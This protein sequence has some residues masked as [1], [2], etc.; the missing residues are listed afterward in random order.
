MLPLRETAR[1]FSAGGNRIVIFVFMVFALLHAV[2]ASAKPAQ[3]QQGLADSATLQ[4][5]V[6]DSHG[7]PLASATVYLQAETKTQTLTA[8]TDSRG[9]FYFS[10]LGHG[11]YTV[12][13]EMA[14]YGE[15]TFGPCVLGA[16]ETKRVDLTLKAEQPQFFDEPE[17]TVAGVT[18]AMNPGGHGSDTILRTTEALAKETAS[19]SKTPLN[20]E[21][22][23]SQ[24]ASAS[25]GTAAEKSLPTVAEQAPTDFDANYR[26]G[27][28]LVDDGKAR[29]AL[30]YL[31]RASQLNPGNYENCYELAFAYAAAGQYER[32]LAQARI[33]LARPD[34]S[35]QEEGEL[36]HLLGDVEEKI[37]DPLEAVR[38]YQRAAELNP[39]ESNLF[40]WG[41][42]LLMHRAYEPAIGVFTKGNR[43]FPQSARMLAGLS[44]AA[45]ARGAYDQA[46]ERLCEAS[47]LSPDDPNPYL[48]LGKMQS[49][50]TAQSECQVER[51]RRFAGLQPENALANYYYA[52]SLWNRHESS[53]SAENVG[54]VESL[55]EKSVHLDPKFGAAYLQLG[56][57]YA[58][59]GDSASAISAYQK[60]TEAN[61]ELEEAHYR[62]AQA[63]SRAGDKSKAEAELQLYQQLSKKSADEAQHERREIQQFVFTLRGSSSALQP[64]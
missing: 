12:R 47:D 14:G 20:K 25:P 26:L 33:L 32:G 44:V 17:F 15:T 61:P 56:I 59:R 1:Y 2:P 4:G 39:S 50:R 10:A 63:Y 48:F 45:Y 36:H 37:G 34:K 64:Q 42:D 53:G 18:E 62:L 41:T 23:N 55:L 5:S 43:L 9:T 8:R 57:L 3:A 22:D 58:E 60:A 11:T 46:A 51:L 49:V 6:R 27:K 54:L 52:L 35:V 19:L 28:L 16:N 13:A 40:D 24:T 21:S 29:E 38:E 31:E 30:R 7:L